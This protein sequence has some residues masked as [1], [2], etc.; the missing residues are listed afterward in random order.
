MSDWRNQ[1]VFTAIAVAESIVIFTIL[2]VISAGLSLDNPPMHWGVV[3]LVY[4]AG[5]VT[6][7]IVGGLRGGIATVALIYGAGGLAT[8]YLAIATTRFND[9]FNFDL[10][11]VYHLFNRDSD[12]G[13]GRGAGDGIDRDGFDLASD[14]HDRAG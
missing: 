14:V 5:M 13:A 9:G 2:A 4:V 12:W 10:A 11:W 6:S 1:I 7:W 3:V 8:I